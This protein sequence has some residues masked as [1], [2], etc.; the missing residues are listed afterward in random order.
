[1]GIEAHATDSFRDH[2]AASKPEWWAK[3]TASSVLL[4]ITD[5]A[6]RLLCLLMTLAW[7]GVVEG[8]QARRKV[9][10]EMLSWSLRKFDRAM[11]ELIDAGL[12]QCDR[13]FDRDGWQDAN[14]WLLVAQPAA[15]KSDEPGATNLTPHKGQSLFPDQKPSSSSCA[16]DLQ[17]LGGREEEL[18]FFTAKNG[19]RGAGEVRDVVEGKDR[20]EGSGEVEHDACN[21]R[22]RWVE[23]ATGTRL[24]AIRS[25]SSEE[26][27]CPECD[28]PV[29]VGEWIVK[30]EFGS[31]AWQWSHVGCWLELEAMIAGNDDEADDESDEERRRAAEQR[32]R[33][34]ANSRAAVAEYERRKAVEDEAREAI[35][36][37]IAQRRQ[38][39]ECYADLVA[40]LDHYAECTC[41]TCKP[42][43]DPAEVEA[44][45]A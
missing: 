2:D 11:K 15:F 29:R 9:L 3:L 40:Q 10:A 8:H 5:R 23:S 28:G 38:A 39:G 20:N 33:Q 24:R 43:P 12:I 16:S 45:L 34:M 44:K 14:R 6:S 13:C 18:S 19:S 26:F 41:P 4:P 30:P 36:A 37:A 17:P 22:G 35:R 21:S 31:E 1:M 27:P 25:R 42:P 32:E 7:N